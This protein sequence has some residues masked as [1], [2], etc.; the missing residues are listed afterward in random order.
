MLGRR[1]QVPGRPWFGLLAAPLRLFRCFDCSGRLSAGWT[2]R[3]PGVGSPIPAPGTLPAGCWAVTLPS[4]KPRHGLWRGSLGLGAPGGRGE[5]SRAGGG[6]GRQRGE[7]EEPTLPPRGAHA[8][9]RGQALQPCLLL[10][11]A[12]GAN[13]M[14]LTRAPKLRPTLPQGSHQLTPPPGARQHPS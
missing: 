6:K 3:P 4:W 7:W 8:G 12:G 9:G 5:G 13:K 11:L 10:S 1:G 14:T 2:L